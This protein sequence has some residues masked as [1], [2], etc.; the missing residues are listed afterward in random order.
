MYWSACLRAQLFVYYSNVRFHLCNRTKQSRATSNTAVD[1][2]KFLSLASQHASREEATILLITD[3]VGVREC[4]VLNGR[5]C[6]LPVGGT[7]WTKRWR[8]SSCLMLVS[9]GIITESLCWH[10]GQEER[11]QRALKTRLHLHFSTLG[12]GR[13]SRRVMQIL[14]CLTGKLVKFPCFSVINPQ[15]TCA[16][17]LAFPSV[18]FAYGYPRDH[19]GSLSRCAELTA[20]ASRGEKK[21]SE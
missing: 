9:R 18:R 19:S 12:C 16:L 7:N 1:I 2:S 5:L 8:G 10:A 4:E 13:Q 6:L 3:N 15:I 11:R 14:I 17:P 20:P 21:A